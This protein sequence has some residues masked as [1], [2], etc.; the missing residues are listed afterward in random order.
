MG[1]LKFTG[2]GANVVGSLGSGSL[3]QDMPTACQFPSATYA[4][5]VSGATTSWDYLDG[6]ATCSWS[7]WFK[8]SDDD[9]GRLFDKF[10]GWTDGNVFYSRIDSGALQ[11][12]IATDATAVTSQVPSGSWFVA[13]TWQNWMVTYDGANVKGY[14]NGVLKDTDALTGALE[15]GGTDQE[16]LNIAAFRG[17]SQDWDGELRDFRI[18][19]SGLTATE[20]AEVSTD[21]NMTGGTATS[22]LVGWWKMEEGTG[23]TLTDSSTETNNAIITG[24]TGWNKSAYNLNQIG[25]GSVS[26]SATVSGGTWNLRDSTTF[27]NLN[28]TSAYYDLGDSSNII[29]GTTVTYSIWF[30]CTDGDAASMYMIS[31][32][33]NGGSTNMSLT[34]NRDDT[35]SGDAGQLSG[36]L[37]N[38]ATHIFAAYD[39]AINDGKWH[40]AVYTTSGS[41]QALYLDGVQVAAGNGTFA[42]EADITDMTIGSFNDGGS[43]FFDGDISTTIID[44]KAWTAE[45][46]ALYYKGQWVGNPAHMFKFNEGAGNASDSGR[47]S[48]TA[49]QQV[50]TWVKSD[51]NMLAEGG[52]AGTLVTISGTKLSA[53]QAE[54][55]LGQAVGHQIGA[56]TYIHNSG[57]LILDGNTGAGVNSKFYDYGNT[58]YNITKEGGGYSH[59]FYASQNDDTVVENTFDFTTSNLRMYYRLNMGTTGSRGTVLINTSEASALIGYGAFE[60]YGVSELYPVLVSSSTVTG[61][62]S[63]R[64]TPTI[65]SNV[66]V[67]MDWTTYGNTITH[68]LS[69]NC[70]FAALTVSLTDIFEVNGQRAEIME[71]LDNQGIYDMDGMTVCHAD[72]DF[73]GYDYR[74]PGEAQIV[75]RNNNNKF[76]SIGN[77]TYKD[78]AF[79]GTNQVRL[80]AN[81]DLSTT[82]VIIGTLQSTDL[83]YDLTC[84]NLTIPAGGIFNGADDTITCE[85]DFNMAGGLIGRGSL[86][87]DDASYEFVQVSG[88]TPLTDMLGTASYTWEMWVSS[89]EGATGYQGLLNLRG[90]WGNNTLGEAGAGDLKWS[91]ELKLDGSDLGD[92]TTNI[93]IPSSI[94]AADTKW[95]H[96][97]GVATSGTGVSLYWDGKLVAQNLFDWDEANWEGRMSDGYISIGKYNAGS[98]TPA[99]AAWKYWDGKIGRTSFW[100]IALTESEIRSMMFQDWGT[101][102]GAD[103][104]D[105]SKCVTWYEFNDR[106]NQTTITDMSGSGSTGTLMV[107]TATGVASDAAS[108]G[109]WA[110]HGTFT[111][112]AST[113]TFSGSAGTTH[114]LNNKDSS[115]N[116]WV[117]NLTIAP[118]N[119]LDVWTSN[120]YSGLYIEGTLTMGAGS[121]I[122]KD[123]ETNSTKLFFTG[124]SW[125]IDPAV[126]GGAGAGILDVSSF[127][128]G[129]YYYGSTPSGAPLN[130][131]VMF[132]ISSSTQGNDLTVGS[133]LQLGTETWDSNGYNITCPRFRSEGAGGSTFL[134]NAGSEINVTSAADSY[135]FGDNV[136][137]TSITAS[138]EACAIFPGEYGGPQDEIDLPAGVLESLPQSTCSISMW[139]NI[140]DDDNSPYEGF[141][142]SAVGKQFTMW[143]QA[144]NRLM[145][146]LGGPAEQFSIYPAVESGVWYHIG[147]TYDG[148]TVKGYFDGTQTGS[149]SYAGSW[150][151]GES[152]IGAYQVGG[153]NTFDGKIADVRIFPTT[154]SD[155]NF[156]TLASENP[157]T[158][159]SGAYADPTNSLGAISWYKLGA[160]TTGTLDASNFGTSGATFDGLINGIVKSGFVTVTGTAGFTMIPTGGAFTESLQN[161]YLSGSRD[162]IIPTDGTVLTKGT[163]VLD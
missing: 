157:A 67:D 130:A 59:T 72:A 82:P 80:I 36:F 14:L 78:I 44:D 145:F 124:D 87:L 70:Q 160:T 138:G 91:P 149:R 131:G 106:Q 159:V 96:F 37:W 54:L 144:A 11:G 19:T 32:I 31:N 142:G 64:S 135:G 95:H 146:S 103:V 152:S 6:A 8:S 93:S 75:M 134:L 51:Y 127:N 55:Q 71:A 73:L 48:V 50:A 56:D 1:V 22:S 141:F 104:I 105:D 155:A 110:D 63:L 111:N 77:N 16:P 161:T 9:N 40:N 151:T 20:V 74:S 49:Q 92:A 61:N 139:V 114:K 99:S 156:V 133:Y 12:V 158:S 143:R 132:G 128:D 102:A 140:K 76:I 98:G 122:Q 69:G 90:S 115:A 2:H 154:L 89:D 29:T 34:L 4:Q 3:V 41:V 24:T 163:V 137:D 113:L 58:Y 81:T 33:R 60:L 27:T 15:S 129:T 123:S 126:S 117:N 101:M 112:N 46:V 53:P 118:N 42:N 116:N 30:N 88:S 43:D 47:G 86:D 35:G 57:T 66:E 38:G 153:S 62:W 13:D 150:T 17:S 68:T 25:A 84:G 39:A 5:V 52:T 28:G 108:T 21:V 125:D 109:L 120:S 65:L 148:A 100:K 162:I 107:G 119:Y 7:I 121:T 79:L 83:G 18:W 136:A 45:Q 26:G 10:N 94:W 147:M 97:A 85:G 23:T